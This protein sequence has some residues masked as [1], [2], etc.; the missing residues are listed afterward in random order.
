MIRRGRFHDVVRR[1]LALFEREQAELLERVASAEREYERAERDEAEERYGD[2]AD[3]VDEATEEL[4]ALRDAYA[5]TLD[6][7]VAALYE[8]EYNHAVLKRYRR[9][10]L[11]LE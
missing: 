1:Q 2:F 7:G 5:A 4:V 9:F 11:E 3:L 10:A 8:H 6:E